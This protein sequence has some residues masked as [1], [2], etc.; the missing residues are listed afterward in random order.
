MDIP[1]IRTWVMF[2]LLS[3]VVLLVAIFITTQNDGQRWVSFMLVVVVVGV[4]LFL[5]VFE[6]KHHQSKKDF[7]RQV[8]KAGGTAGERDSS[9]RRR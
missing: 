1:E 4:N 3:F 7:V 8:S 6:L 5:L 2:Y 9:G